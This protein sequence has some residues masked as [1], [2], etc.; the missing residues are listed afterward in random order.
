MKCRLSLVSILALA[1]AGAASARAAL[2]DSAGKTV[3]QAAFKIH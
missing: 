3:N 1:T 2:R